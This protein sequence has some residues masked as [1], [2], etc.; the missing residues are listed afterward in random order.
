[1][2]YK[3]LLPIFLCYFPLVYSETNLS[4]TMNNK[5]DIVEFNQHK[6]SDGNWHFTTSDGYEVRKF[7][8]SKY[9]LVHKK[10]PDSPYLKVE[11]YNSDGVL[12]QKGTQF[13]DINIDLEDYDSQGNMLKKTTYDTPYNLTIEKLRTIIKNE[14]DRDIMDKN[15]IYALTRFEDKQITNQSYYLVRYID[16]QNKRQLHQVLL[17]GNTGEILKTADSYFFGANIDVWQEYLKS[18]KTK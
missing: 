5:F 7:K 13:Y 3:W 1:M 17:N 18:L 14:Y 16:S 10:L 15:Q 8:A 6:G 11:A 2:Y 4:D 9:Y 12:L